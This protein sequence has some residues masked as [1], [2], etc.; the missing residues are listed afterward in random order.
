MQSASLARRLGRAPATYCTA[1]GLAARGLGSAQLGQSRPGHP[2]YH[3]DHL[4]LGAAAAADP[5][6]ASHTPIPQVLDTPASSTAAT[7]AHGAGHTASAPR[8][9]LPERGRAAPT[10]RAHPTR[11]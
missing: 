5:V 2:T 11:A 1:L 4:R 3:A 6:S 10:G 9:L 8:K 7:G